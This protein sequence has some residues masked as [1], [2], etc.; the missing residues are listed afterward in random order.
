MNLTKCVKGNLSVCGL[1]RKIGREAQCSKF[2]EKLG[3]G[4]KRGF[5]SKLRPWP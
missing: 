2:E 5:G 3:M 4:E 1:G